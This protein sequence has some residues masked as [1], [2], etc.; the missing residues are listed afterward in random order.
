MRR[1][2]SG[3]VLLTKK[4]SPPPSTNRK[5]LLQRRLRSLTLQGTALCRPTESIAD[6]RNPTKD[7]SSS[8]RCGVVPHRRHC[9]VALP[10]TPGSTPNVEIGRPSMV[11]AAQGRGEIET[12]VGLLPGT[13]IDKRLGQSGHRPSEKKSPTKTCRLICMRVKQC[14]PFHPPVYLQ[15]FAST[16]APQDVRHHPCI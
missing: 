9:R 15:T 6:F 16:D 2:S 5:D 4:A 12:P 10:S 13:E 14:Y 7:T 3:D 1:S 8:P 11:L